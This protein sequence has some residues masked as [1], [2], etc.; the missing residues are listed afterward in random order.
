MINTVASIFIIGLS[1]LLAFLTL[2]P[3]SKIPHGLVR[4]PAFVRLQMLA[5]ALVLLPFAWVLTS[6][7]WRIFSLL[8]L[9]VVIAVCTASVLKF[10][11]LWPKQSKS[12]EA[13][14]MTDTDRHIHM[15]A[16]NVKMSNREY[17]HLIALARREQ[18]DVLAALE[19]DQRWIDALAVLEPDYIHRYDVPH[20]TGYGMMLY[21]KLPLKDVQIR[22]LVT[23]GVPSIKATVTLRSGDEICLYIVHPEPPVAHEKTT[24]R[25]SEIA[26]AGLEAIDGPLPAIIAGDLNDVAWSTTTRRFQRV[27]GL[28]DPRV[29]RGFYNTFN[30]YVPVFRWPLDHLFHD[31]RF[32]FVQMQRMPKIGSDHF[33]ISFKLVLAHRPAGEAPTPEEGETEDVTEMIVEEQ[34]RDRD[35][36]GTDWEDEK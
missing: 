33:P 3:F 27:T 22:D 19:T 26:L 21:S 16:A 35:P 5:T 24:G 2:V 8:C 12:A 31:A 6:D 4:A 14:L 32:R 18:P 13:A 34:A 25:D 11:P 23:K 15:L 7:G 29:G 36:V 20:D 9:V 30:A 10:T 17:D 28:L 1:G